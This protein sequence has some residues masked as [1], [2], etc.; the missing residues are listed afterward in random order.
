MS[1]FDGAQM[2]EHLQQRQ[3]QEVAYDPEQGY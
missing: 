3:R 1:V 2:M